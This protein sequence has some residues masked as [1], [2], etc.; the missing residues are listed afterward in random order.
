MTRRAVTAGNS[1]KAFMGSE[2]G[3]CL[4]NFRIWPGVMR[5]SAA[6][7]RSSIVIMFV[8]F[9]AC[10]GLRYR[11][12]RQR[13]ASQ[14]P[15]HNFHIL[16]VL[17]RSKPRVPARVYLWQGGLGAFSCNS[18]GP[19]RSIF[20]QSGGGSFRRPHFRRYLA[21]GVSECVIKFW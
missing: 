4:K 8:P 18:K 17:L 5:S 14:D 12:L 1:S 6:I 20:S 9:G 3:I 21:T 7:G 19:S 16:G 15:G 10:R 13:P 11:R 2:D